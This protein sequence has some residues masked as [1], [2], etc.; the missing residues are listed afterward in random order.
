MSSW[1]KNH[2]LVAYFSLAIAFSWAVY[3]PLV[4][5]RQGWTSAPIPY[6]IHYLAAFGPALAALIVTALT[7]GK[8]GLREL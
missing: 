7:S 4:A 8:E 1:F 2:A 3:I 5:V 6:S